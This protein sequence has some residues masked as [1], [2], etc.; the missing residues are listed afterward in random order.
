MRSFA[1]RAS[2]LKVRCC[3]TSYFTSLFVLYSRLFYIPGVFRLL[4]PVVAG[5]ACF[6]PVSCLFCPLLPFRS[7]FPCGSSP[8]Y[9][10]G[11]LFFSGRLSLWS[12]LPRAIFL[13]LTALTEVL[14]AGRPAPFSPDFSLSPFLPRKDNAAE[15]RKSE[16][17]TGKRRRH[18]CRTRAEVTPQLRRL[19]K[20]KQSGK[21]A[22]T[23]V[24]STKK[25]NF[26]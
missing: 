24:F 5:V 15:F 26:R 12:P 11:P 22:R 1:W 18:N 23:R 19:T 2:P 9:F 8:P 6:L 3:V 7:L 13:W 4:V 10:R 14:G 20:R 25:R 17:A 21:S 16:P